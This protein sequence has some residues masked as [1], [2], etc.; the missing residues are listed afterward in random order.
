MSTAVTAPQTE[1]QKPK[2]EDEEFNRT[3]NFI[4]DFDK[5]SDRAVVIL[6]AARIDQLLGELLRAFLM[7][8][9]SSKDELFDADGPLGTFSSRI[10][11]A[12]RLGLLNAQF[13][14]SLTMLRKCRNAFAHQVTGCSMQD[15]SEADRV[16]EFVRIFRKESVWEN[17]RDLAGKSHSGLSAEFRAALGYIV[18]VLESA[19]AART[20]L[21]G[22][23]LEFP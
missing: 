16:R 9:P 1:K 4:Q 10:M 19:V 21:P 15:G 20:R 3:F 5:E 7:P 22:E 23:P 12:F 13:V 11:M 2:H 6:G 18:I 17:L 14:Q 8:S